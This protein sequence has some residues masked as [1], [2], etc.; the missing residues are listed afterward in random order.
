MN[1]SP[2]ECLQ[3]QNSFNV[4]A[5]S[6]KVLRPSSVEA[7]QEIAEMAE[8]I[9]QRFYILG[10]G[11]NTLFVDE[12]APTIIQP[13]FSGIDITE[14]DNH[15]SVQVGASENWHN[16]VCLCIEQG[17]N[18]L[19]N[20]ALIPGSVGAAPVQNIGAYGVEFADFCHE[21]TFFDFSS[22]KVMALSNHDCQ[23]GYRDSIFK[24]ALYN[25]GVITQVTL[26]FPKS[27]QGK[28]SYHG[29]NTLPA[30]ATAKT[31]MDMVIQLRQSKLPDPNKLPNAG[32]FFKNPV[33]S[34]DKF[35]R[36]QND[37]PSIPNYPQAN[38]EIKL[39]AGWLIE[40]S[41]LKGGI[42]KGVGIHKKQALVLVNY[43]QGSG[44]D[45]LNLAKYV[46]QQVKAKFGIEIIP[47]VRMISALGEQAFT[48]FSH[49]DL[50]SELT[51]D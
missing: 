27:W 25:Q 49:F 7:L 45:L 22:K 18:G 16:L 44:K 6:H 21:V 34:S 43:A 15:F 10:E 37:Y 31:I 26:N 42:Y 13:K 50:I 23:F 12:Q 20:L 1:S 39:A 3:T 30:T 4:K 17:I 36:L 46:Q 29:L 33:I 2:Q 24:G 48:A 28:T 9:E 47:E 41:G 14:H 11:S 5:Y 40:Q 38:G 51:Y 35:K 8:V 32:S 19:E